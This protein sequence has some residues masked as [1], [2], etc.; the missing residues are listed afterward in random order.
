MLNQVKMIHSHI[1]RNIPNNRFLKETKM[2]TN[3][4]IITIN[5][6]I[7]EVFAYVSNLENGPKWQPEL[8]EVRRITKGPVKI[9]SQF[10][11]ARIIM[12]QKMVTSSSSWLMSQIVSTPL[13][14]SQ[15]LCLLNKR[16]FLSLLLRAPNSPRRSNCTQVAIWPRQNQCLRNFKTG[17]GD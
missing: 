5:R 3:E 9:G 1:V 7:N 6:P 16:P 4:K 10:S 11:S 15:A 12:G 8:S 13:K 2:V 17:N 14:A